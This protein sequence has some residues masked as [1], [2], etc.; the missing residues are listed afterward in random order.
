VVKLCEIAWVISL[1]RSLSSNHLADAGVGDQHFDRR[2]A[3]LAIRARHQALRDHGPQ[4]R[5]QLQPDL[6]L[7]VRR[8][9]PRRCARDG[10]GSVEGVQGG[11]HQVSGLRRGQRGL[12][13]LQVAHFAHQDHVGSWR[14]ADLSACA[15]ESVS[16]PTS[17]G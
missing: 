16:T 8:K 10:L 11:E 7:L 5:A 12:D 15:K 2:D 9:R 13:G 14:S 3:S 17:A 4:H 1:V 6:L